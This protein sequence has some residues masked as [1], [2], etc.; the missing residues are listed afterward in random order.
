MLRRRRESRDGDDPK[1]QRTDNGH[2][3][4]VR[5][6]RRVPDLPNRDATTDRPE[7]LARYSIR[8]DRTVG[9]VCRD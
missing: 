2:H 9:V 7:W 4:P 3:G 8:Y 1:R 5:A 6:R